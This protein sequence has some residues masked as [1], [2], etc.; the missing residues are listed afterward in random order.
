MDLIDDVDLVAGRSCAVGH[1]VDDLADVTH[2]GAR[3]GIHLHNIHMATF[4]DRSAM[5]AFAAGLR[6]RAALTVFP[7][8]VHA[9][10]DDPRGGGFAG[11]ANTCHNE[12][13]RNAIRG[14]GVLQRAHHRVLTDQIGKGLG[15][16]LACQ[17][18]ILSALR[19]AGGLGA[20]LAHEGLS[21]G[22]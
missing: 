21:D 5:F 19:C 12:G 20:V 3:G 18:L 9:L 1:T 8:A 22:L 4:H 7:D 16:I 11:A 14:K 13:L 2:T 15:P 10:G 6:G 17:N